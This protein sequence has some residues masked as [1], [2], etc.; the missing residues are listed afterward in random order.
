MSPGESS[1]GDDAVPT[2]QSQF[3]ALVAAYFMIVYR[4][5]AGRVSLDEEGGG[6]LLSSPLER[7]PFDHGD[8]W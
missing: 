5:F 2:A 3:M 8:P 4:R 7:Q 1:I 6:R